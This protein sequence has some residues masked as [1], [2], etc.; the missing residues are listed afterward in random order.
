LHAA[1][2]RRRDHRRQSRP[3]PFDVDGRRSL[4]AARRS[5]EQSTMYMRRI[6][7]SI[8]RSPGQWRD[9]HDTRSAM[10]RAPGTTSP[11]GTATTKRGGARSS[12]RSRPPATTAYCR[13]S[14]KIPR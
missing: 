1:R 14:M 3:Q 11:S 5:T 2:S 6:R 10:S 8:R 13:S 12:P 9:R 4:A 7:G